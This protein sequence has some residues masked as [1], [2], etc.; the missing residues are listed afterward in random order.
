MGVLEAG[1]GESKIMEAMIER[2]IGDGDAKGGHIGE[3]RQAGA[4]GSMRLPEND[5]LLRAVNGAPSADAPL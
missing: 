4:T 5:L 2:L 1:T 3:I